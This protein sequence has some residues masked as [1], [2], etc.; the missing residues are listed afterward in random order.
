MLSTNI[1]FCCEGSK[2]VR[3]TLDTG[4]TMT[5]RDQKKKNLI[6]KKSNKSDINRVG[7]ESTSTVR[8]TQMS[9][10]VTVYQV[11]LVGLE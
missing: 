7:K 10:R 5:K 2:W 9:Q 6:N 8:H 3:V 11:T 4:K 1:G